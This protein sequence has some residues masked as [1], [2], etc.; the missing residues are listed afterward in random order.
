MA[1]VQRDSCAVFQDASYVLPATI[2]PLVEAARAQGWDV[3]EEIAPH[4]LERLY[5]TLTA[6]TA[7]GKGYVYL[8]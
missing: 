5:L 6:D 2:A 8:V 7:A 4:A 1:H 3:K